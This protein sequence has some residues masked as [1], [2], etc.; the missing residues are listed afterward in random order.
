LL[1]FL[2]K[3]KRRGGITFKKYCR[4]KSPFLEGFLFVKLFLFQKKKFTAQI[5]APATLPESGQA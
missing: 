4:Y 5:E 1:L 3:R 2:S